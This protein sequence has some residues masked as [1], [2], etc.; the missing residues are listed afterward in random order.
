MLATSKNGLFQSHN[1]LLTT[2]TD[3]PTLDY[4]PSAS[5]SY[6]TRVIVKVPV[7]ITGG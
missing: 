7:I 3:D 6:S 1:C 4:R 5:T 2:G